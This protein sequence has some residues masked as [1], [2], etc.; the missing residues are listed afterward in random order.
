MQAQGMTS[1][2]LSVMVTQPY[3]LQ[4]LTSADFALLIRVRSEK[5]VKYLSCR[6][7]PSTV[8]TQSGEFEPIIVNEDIC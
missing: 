2:M 6:I 3:S 8:N 5:F 1:A 4:M 7:S